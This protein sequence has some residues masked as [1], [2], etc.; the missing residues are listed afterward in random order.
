MKNYLLIAV[1]ILWSGLA[2]AQPSPQWGKLESLRQKIVLPHN[3][4]DELRYLASF[5]RTFYEYQTVFGG[6]DPEELELSEVYEQ[7]LD[8]LAKLAKKYLG[9]H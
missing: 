4:N 2:C 1:I 5:P 9:K 7:H 6:N 8:V 3:D